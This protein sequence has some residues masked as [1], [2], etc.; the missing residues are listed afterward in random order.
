MSGWATQVGS[1][2]P[3]T[4]RAVNTAVVADPVGTCRLAGAG[5][6]PAAALPDT[7]SYSTAGFA[8]YTPAGAG[9]PYARRAGS[10]C[11][12][13][14][15]PNGT[16]A[17][18]AFTDQWSK[19]S[20]CAAH[21]KAINC[22]CFDHRPGVSADLIGSGIEGSGPVVLFGREPGSPSLVGAIP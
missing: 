19:L 17:G 22:S 9:R 6:Q 5:A 10:H 13:D 3:R 7:A 2:D 16:C 21:C 4:G 18:W 11:A 8:A 1:W 20:D 14:F 12:C 15:M